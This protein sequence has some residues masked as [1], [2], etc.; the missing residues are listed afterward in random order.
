MELLLN[1]VE[2]LCLRLGQVAREIAEER[3]LAETS[4]IAVENDAGRRRRRGKI[5]VI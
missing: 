5:T 1:R 3:L 2:H 4:F